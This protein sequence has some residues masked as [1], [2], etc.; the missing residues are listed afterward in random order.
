ML[1]NTQEIL[2]RAIEHEQRDMRDA[3]IDVLASEIT[4]VDGGHIV[5]LLYAYTQPP[6]TTRSGITFK[7]TSGVRYSVRPPGGGGASGIVS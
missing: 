7:E 3:E 4:K 5:Y 1:I 2:D 6:W